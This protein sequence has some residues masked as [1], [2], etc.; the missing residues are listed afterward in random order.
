[1]P[2]PERTRPALI[3]MELDRLI[4]AGRAPFLRNHCSSS[5]ESVEFGP[6]EMSGRLSRSDGDGR[7]L[8]GAIDGETMTDHP[9]FQLL[10]AKDVWPLGRC[11]SGSKQRSAS[12]ALIL[13]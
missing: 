6:S 9:D 10:P 7:S 1:M 11:V 8:D 3:S 12:L 13:S 5:A 2:R 4:L